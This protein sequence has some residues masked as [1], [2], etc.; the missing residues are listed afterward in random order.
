[1][2]S[3]WSSESIKW[4]WG[5]GPQGGR[6]DIAFEDALGSL[7]LRRQVFLVKR[8]QTCTITG[9]ILQLVLHT[10]EIW[11]YTSRNLV[12]PNISNI[13]RHHS[14]RL[15]FISPEYFSNFGRAFSTRS[16]DPLWF[17]TSPCETHQ[18]DP[19]CCSWYV[20]NKRGCCLRCES[21]STSFPFLLPWG[22]STTLRR[23]FCMSNMSLIPA[24][25]P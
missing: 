22:T 14:F 24:T 2:F 17:K 1:M 25:R 19:R 23:I 13:K 16:M 12:I 3:T 8:S 11:Y 18:I 9:I 5:S 15:H 6:T 21:S 10:E 7:S 20:W 4:P